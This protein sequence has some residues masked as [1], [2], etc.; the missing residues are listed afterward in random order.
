M[1]MR[2]LKYFL[3]VAESEHVTQASEALH[4]AQS[5]ISR[6]ISN[7]EN[8]LGVQLFIRQGRNV[9]LTPIGRNF[10]KHIEKAMQELDKAVIEV[11]E[12]LDPEV[13]E[14]RVGFPHSLAAYTMPTVVSAFRKRYPNV[15]FQLMQGTVAQMVD[16][17]VS[18]ELDVA[19]VSP[20]PT[21]HAELDGHVFFTEEMVAILPVDHR[22]AGESSIRLIQLK[23]DPFVMFR[24]GFIMR[25]IIKE[26]CELAGFEPI[27][28]FEGED[29]VSVR[30]LVAA[31]LGVGLL[32]S[33]AIKEKSTNVVSLP[34]SE[35]RITRTVGFVTHKKREH[36]PTVQL[37]Q[38]FL[39]QYY[40]HT[41]P[42]A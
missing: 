28:A 17:M 34:I 36:A 5:A 32:P 41:G 16:D 7:L 33:I 3:A 9:K 39:W 11:Q 18:G 29:S 8:E 6:Q 23:D 12:Y 13:G 10:K 27:V 42:E 15:R 40:Q 4:V 26:A 22:L 25:S 38:Q 30:G 20:V 24:S 35:P 1:E 21:D 2:Q 14:V 31:G 37:F 19:F